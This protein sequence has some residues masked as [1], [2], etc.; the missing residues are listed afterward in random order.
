V[1]TFGLPQQFL[2]HGSRDEILEDAGLTSLN[3]TR[4][5]TR[6]ITR[7]TPELAASPEL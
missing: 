2:G 5:I 1:L 4:E 6:C 7:Q 3:L